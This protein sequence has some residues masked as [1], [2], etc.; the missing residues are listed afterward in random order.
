RS[1]PPPS[2]RRTP[3]PSALPEVILHGAFFVHPSQPLRSHCRCGQQGT[4]RRGRGARPA[5]GAKGTSEAREAQQLWVWQRRDIQRRL[6]L[7]RREASRCWWRYERTA[8]GGISRPV[9]HVSPHPHGA[10]RRR[11]AAVARRIRSPA[12][13]SELATKWIW[14]LSWRAARGLHR[15][16]SPPSPTLTTHPGGGDARGG[17]TAAARQEEAKAARWSPRAGTSLTTSNPARHNTS[18]GARDKQRHR[19]RAT[20]LEGV[21]PCRNY[22]E[23]KMLGKKMQLHGSG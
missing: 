19:I 8:A 5:G 17:A 21:Q 4:G 13:A 22:N 11:P 7:R 2:A 10:G 1:L 3:L 15:E 23:L 12:S 16:I 9:R 14:A 18:P 6:G 20:A